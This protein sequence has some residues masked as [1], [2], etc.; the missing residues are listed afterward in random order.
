MISVEDVT[1]SYV[2]GKSR[3]DVLRGIQCEIPARSLTFIVG[4]S[5]SGKSTLL[6]LMGAL[7]D[8]TSGEIRIDG[9][10]LREL[11]HGQR[12]ELRR[13]EI[14]FVFQSFNLLKNLSALD[15]VLVPFLP[16][17]CPAA[18]RKRGQELL[19]RIG[20]GDRLHHRPSTLSGG[21]QQ[22]V[23]IARAILKQPKVILADEPTGELDSKTGRVVFDMLR[24]L[25]EEQGA[26]IVTVTHDD[27]YI[28]PGDRVLTIEDGRIVNQRTAG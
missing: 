10:A 14:G 3:V 9:R 19:G 8:P 5:G 1:K 17:G 13:S 7:D 28:R 2:K 20:L 11:S 4:P 16:V 22:R 24:E 27:R 21:E 25:N 6:Y 12:N 18:T 26:T 23:A 15:N